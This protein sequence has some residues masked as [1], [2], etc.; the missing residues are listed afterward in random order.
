MTA[1]LTGFML[2]SS[3]S[4]PPVWASSK[5]TVYLIL[6]NNRDCVADPKADWVL[7]SV[8]AKQK[9]HGE[10]QLKAEFFKGGGHENMQYHL[11]IAVHP[12]S[13]RCQAGTLHTIEDSSFQTNKQ[14]A[15]KKTVTIDDP[16]ANFHILVCNDSR[17]DCSFGGNFVY[18]DGQI[19]AANRGQL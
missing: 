1:A 4:A 10:V 18:E 12:N 3:W 7:G 15:G 9:K 6:D 8:V 13:T 5:P 16:G 17:D 14:A 2:A 11:E 19:R